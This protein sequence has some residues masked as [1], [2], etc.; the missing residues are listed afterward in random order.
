LILS[1]VSDKRPPQLFEG[2][3]HLCLQLEHEERGE[4]T[5]LGPLKIA[6]FNPFFRTCHTTPERS[7]IR[8][9]RAKSVEGWSSVLDSWG[10]VFL[11]R[12]FY[13]CRVQGWDSSNRHRKETITKLDVL[14]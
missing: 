5:L 2:W 7:A 3:N 10:H 8:W 11:P 9:F 12:S 6:N 4:A 14:K 13:G 1:F